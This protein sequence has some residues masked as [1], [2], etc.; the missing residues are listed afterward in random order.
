MVTSAPRI[1]ILTFYHP[2]DLAA[3][4]FRVAALI[5]ALRAA[6]P[7]VGIDVITTLPNRYRGFAADAPQHETHDGV[8]VTR[9][10]LPPHASGMADQARA[11]LAFAREASRLARAQ[12]HDLVFATSSRLM[13]AAL[14]ARLA[15]RDDVPLYLDLRDIFVDT[16]TEV[17]GGARGR[18]LAPALSALERWTVRR[19]ARVNLISRGFA[20]WFTTRYPGRA[21]SYFTNGVD[22]EVIPPPRPERARAAGTPVRVLYAG[23]IGEGQGLHHVLP[24][25]A[26]RLAGRAEFRV[27][28]DGGR[29]EPLAAAVAGMAN[30]TLQPPMS[31][32]ALRAEYER[33]DVL[34][35]HLNDLRAFHKVLPSKVFEYAATGKPLW[36]GVAGHAAT[37]ITEEVTNAAVFAP[38][39]VEGALEAF[40]RLELRDRARPEFIARHARAR[41]MAEMAAD[42]LSLL[43]GGRTVR[44]SA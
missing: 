16:I 11:F 15:G 35:L 20:G 41:I 5:R 42:V 10:A 30:V 14:G 38:C 9:I 4:S 7:A 28:G 12:R 31:R 2:P 29:R 22:V 24:A 40:G 6:A 33:A 34:F 18:L 21:F 17:L 13:T 43:P 19:A 27:V 8:S 25:L 37:F 44:G 26:R 3:G 23:N 32:E 39:D 1:L 36:A